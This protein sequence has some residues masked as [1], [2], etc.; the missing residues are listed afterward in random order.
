[1]HQS[2]GMGR[3][4]PPGGYEG[5]YAPG[6]RPSPASRIAQ[7]AGYPKTVLDH[8]AW[9]L[10][11]KED[12]EAFAEYPYQPRSSYEGYY[13][14]VTEEELYLSSY[15]ARIA[16]SSTHP[17]RVPPY[18]RPLGGPRGYPHQPHPLAIRAHGYVDERYR[19]SREASYIDEAF[20]RSSS[21]ATALS[22][23]SREQDDISNRLHE[24]DPHREYYSSGLPKGYCSKDADFLFS[25]N[26]S[27][28]GS[29]LGGFEGHETAATSTASLSSLLAPGANSLIHPRALSQKSS[30]STELE[31]EDVSLLS[32]HSHLTASHAISSNPLS[33]TA[34]EFEELSNSFL[35]LGLLP[36]QAPKNSSFLCTVIEKSTSDATGELEDVVSPISDK[37]EH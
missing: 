22:N 21:L 12:G 11:D 29:G 36:S 35:S 18:P 17:T 37:P 16:T 5:G 14:D 26:P 3:G 19:E 25:G 13:D 31:A 10:Y 28:L 23:F 27:L 4:H 9:G 32:S 20:D 6:Y 34:P 7:S 24:L 1:M 8:G 15:P 2:M 33:V 30:V